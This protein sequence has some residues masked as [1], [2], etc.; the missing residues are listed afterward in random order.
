MADKNA[1]VT[2]CFTCNKKAIGWSLAELDFIIGLSRVCAD[3]K[4]QIQE[5]MNKLKSNWQDAAHR[6][7]GEDG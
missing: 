3:C 4:K 6:E 1:T 5:K 7:P 2:Q